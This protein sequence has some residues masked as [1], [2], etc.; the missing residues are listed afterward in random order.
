MPKKP[1]LLL[2]RATAVALA[3]CLRQ[4]RI[5]ADPPLTQKAAA[6]VL[7]ISPTTLCQVEKGNQEPSLQLIRT[8]AKLYKVHPNVILGVIYMQEFCM[9]ELDPEGY[10]MAEA[11]G[12]IRVGDVLTPEQ[13]LYARERL[14]S[15]GYKRI[16]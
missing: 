1:D 6:G 13:R 16:E 11:S 14:H 12:A 9:E 8:A 3:A 5:T 15:L 10:L 7:G 2:D 4:L